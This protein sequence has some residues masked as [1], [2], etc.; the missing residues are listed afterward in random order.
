MSTAIASLSPEQLA[1]RQHGLGASEVA[2]ILG[3]DPFRTALDVY[4]DKTGQVGP[5]PENRFMRWGKRLE[6]V[7]ADEYAA[8][9][10]ERELKPSGTV[11]GPEPWMLAT[12]DRLV[13]GPGGPSVPAWGL[14]CKSRG[15]YNADAWG[16]SGSDEVP[17]AVAVQCHWGMIVTAL[18]RWDVAVLLGGNDYREYTLAWDDT[19]ARELVARART[20]WFDHVQA[21]VH[22]PFTGAPSDHAFLLKTYPEHTGEMVPATVEITEKATLLQVHRAAIDRHMAEK[23]R[24]EAEIKEFIGGRL[25]VEGPFGRITWTHQDPAEVKAYTRAAYRR[26]VAKWARKLGTP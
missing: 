24:L 14:E 11:T 15:H 13:Y 3:L 12:P 10:P 17:H 26:F 18:E 21:K 2:A 4:L 25:G 16:E 7:I 19:I 8:N 1:L 23:D 9:H 5:L 22:P 20:F 6:A